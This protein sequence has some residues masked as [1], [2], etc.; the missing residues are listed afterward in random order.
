[1][2]GRACSSGCGEC[3]ESDVRKN[4]DEEAKLTKAEEK[5]RLRSSI[6]IC[7]PM[8]EHFTSHLRHR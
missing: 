2:F 7:V 6:W 3:P 8:M 5:K 1:M 4:R